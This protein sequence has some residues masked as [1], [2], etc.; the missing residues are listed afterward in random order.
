MGQ[1]SGLVVVV[2]DLFSSVYILTNI[3]LFWPVCKYRDDRAYIYRE[4]ESIHGTRVYYS[5]RLKFVEQEQTKLVRTNS[6]TREVKWRGSKGSRGSSS[7]NRHTHTHVC[8]LWHIRPRTKKFGS[9]P[10][11]VLQTIYLLCVYFILL[12]GFLLT[13]F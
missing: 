8:I 12:Y 2:I 5:Q 6:A 4:R 7:N 11:P 9:S 3:R 1:Q 13:T 10:T